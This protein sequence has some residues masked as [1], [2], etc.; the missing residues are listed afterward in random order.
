M[1]SLKSLISRRCLL[2]RATCCLFTPKTIID[3][4]FMLLGGSLMIESY[5]AVIGNIVFAMDRQTWSLAGF[6]FSS[7]DDNRDPS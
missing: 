3:I 4:G 7:S 5:Y 2:S 6:L 1:L